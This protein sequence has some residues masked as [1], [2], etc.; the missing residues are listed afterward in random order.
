[1]QL[2]EKL[3][4]PQQAPWKFQG[5]LVQQIKCDFKAMGQV[6]ALELARLSETW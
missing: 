6:L 5:E 4:S 3:D 1:M 2:N